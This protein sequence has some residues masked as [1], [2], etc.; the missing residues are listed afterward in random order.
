MRKNLR[1]ATVA[2]AAAGL[3]LIP[4][5]IASATGNGEGPH[6]NGDRDATCTYDQQQDRLHLQ[7]GTGVRHNTPAST[8]GN[9]HQSGSLDGTA[10]AVRPLDGTGHQWGGA[11]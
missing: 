3:I 2:A 4:A 9:G 11:S 10:Q 7:D 1:I 5:G 8:V 6:R